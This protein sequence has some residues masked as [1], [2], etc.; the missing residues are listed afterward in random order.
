MCTSFGEI[1]AGVVVDKGAI[2]KTSIREY[3]CK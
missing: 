1:D 3:V 2:G